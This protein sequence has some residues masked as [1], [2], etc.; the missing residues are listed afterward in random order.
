MLE[1]LKEYLSSTVNTAAQRV[2]NPVFGAFA[3]SWC[4]FNWKS[5]LYLLL[6]D[7]S[8]IDKITYISSNSSWKTVLAFPCVS[9][10]ILCGG[11]PWINN[12]ISKW[13]AK[14]LDNYDSIENHRKAKRIHRATRLQRLKAK[15]DV[16]YDK[17]K[18]GAEKDIQAMKER[19]TESQA[20]MGELTSERDRLSDKVL[21]L[22]KKL[23]NMQSVAAALKIEAE[24]SARMLE[25]REAKI[26][27][28][29]Q[30]LKEKEKES[31]VLH[32]GHEPLRKT[33]TSQ[34]ER[35]IAE[36]VKNKQ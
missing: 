25:D 2:R 18:T 6:S 1:S 35:M 15:H 7:S 31:I 3:L 4:A 36:A 26:N 14:P 12:V 21:E 22:N 32:M 30:E 9:A 23:E 13:Q 8:I 17:V 5:I 33:Y 10:I 11:M 20:R 24:K 19:I 27:N 28:L 34:A 29:I 16:T